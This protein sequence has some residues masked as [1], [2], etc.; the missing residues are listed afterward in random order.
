MPVF[1]ITSP[2]GKKYRVTAPDG[3]TREQ[4]LARIKESVSATATDPPEGFGA[5]MDREISAIPR[6]LGLAARYGIEGPARAVGI[7]SNPLAFIQSK[8]TGQPVM[9]AGDLG[10][11]VADKL[12][13]PSPETT[14]E[15]VVG[16]GARMMTGIGGQAG[17]ASRV[18]ELA[19]P[20]VKG[21]AGLLAQSP[22]TQLA[23]AAGGGLLGQ[24]AAETG[25][26]PVSQAGAALAGSFGA[27]GAALL[28]GKLYSSAGALVN[29]LRGAKG[30]IEQIDKRLG[31]ILK[32][33]GINLSDLPNDIRNQ[34]AKEIE[35]SAITGAKLDPAVIRRIADYGVVGANPTMGSVTLD[36]VRITAERNLAK[37]GANSGDPR[38]QQLARNQRAND[39]QL[40]ESINTL[41]AGRA[42][43][44][45][46]AGA[47]MMDALRGKDIPR[48]AAVDAAYKAVRDSQGRYANI[49]VPAFSKMA[50]DSL[51]ENMLGSALPGQ[52]KQ[53]LNDVSSGKI[54]LNVNTMV[55]LDKR[56]SGIGNDAFRTG[57]SE[58]ALAVRK[59]RDALNN[60][61]VDAGAGQQA[62]VLY[63]NARK[64]AA[65]R[66]KSIDENP[67]MKAALD[68][69][70][71]DKFVQQYIIGSGKDASVRHT[72]SLARDLRNPVH[73]PKGN[74]L[75]VTQE[76]AAQLRQVPEALQSAKT[77]ILLYLK[78]KAL[79]GAADEVAN[80]SPSAYNKALGAIGDQKLS[81]FFNKSD[82]SKIKAIGRVAAYEKF[83]PSGSAVNNSNTGA[84]FYKLLEKI[85]SSSIASRI[86]FGQSVLIDPARNWSA[87]H[88]AKD[89]LNVYGSVALPRPSQTGSFPVAP[90]L[91]PGLLSTEQ[92]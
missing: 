28:A 85:G 11:F 74:T 29:S 9:P 88:A 91:M 5:R 47:T 52:A 14:T 55:Q 56:L 44:K 83:Q 19:S 57:N 82:L 80:F 38:L 42:S 65:E 12:G 34:L 45:V 77:Q 81:L 15:R 22:G 21:A 53:L 8:M 13:L 4:A 2:D 71:P 3:A 51:D 35:K 39:I 17:V 76:V 92:P 32:P 37:F 18:A 31:A 67:A 10:S 25:G 30:G 84:A 79:N 48:K 50:N 68:G 1:E 59:V 6:Q 33:N 27:S 58:G 87:Q 73:V 43:D 64:L 26:G 63:E 36:P 20:V 60:A 70:D 78:N 72:G 66:F 40:T 16:E 90:L 54:P 7:V 23:G 49:D 75:P 62:K 86:P 41:G 89:A 61:P 46:S 69:A 24:Y